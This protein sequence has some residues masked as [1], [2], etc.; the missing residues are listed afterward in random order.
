MLGFCHQLIFS[1]SESTFSENYFGNRIRVSNAVLSVLVTL[2]VRL[3]SQVPHLEKSC[4]LNVY[5]IFAVQQ[6]KSLGR[7]LIGDLN[8]KCSK[9]QIEGKIPILVSTC[10]YATC[11]HKS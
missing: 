1:L 10:K 9:A 2:T 11:T 3:Q 7:A 8:S 5:Y 6:R 4:D